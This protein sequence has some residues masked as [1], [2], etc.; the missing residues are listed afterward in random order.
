MFWADIPSPVSHL[1][2]DREFADS[3]LEEGGFEPS[4]PR[5]ENYAHEITLSDCSAFPF[6]RKGPTFELLFLQ[7][8]FLVRT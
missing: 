5:K 1:E 3:P 2:G 4:V 6:I 8:R 7:R